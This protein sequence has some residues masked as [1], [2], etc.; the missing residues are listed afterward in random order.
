MVPSKGDRVNAKSAKYE[1]QNPMIHI[2]EEAVKPCPC[3]YFQGSYTFS[4]VKFK[5][6]SRTKFLNLKDLIYYF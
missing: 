1:F 3:W 4:A 6:F 5:D 2:I